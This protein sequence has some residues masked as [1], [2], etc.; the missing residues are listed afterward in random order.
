MPAGRDRNLKRV[1]PSQKKRKEK[2]A[3]DPAVRQRAA[4]HAAAAEAAHAAAAEAALAAAPAEQAGAAGPAREKAGRSCRSCGEPTAGHVGPYGPSCAAAKAL[5][6]PENMRS[7][8]GQ[9][10]LGSLTPSPVRG[11][12][13]QEAA[14]ADTSVEKIDE[15]IPSPS[16]PTPPCRCQSPASRHGICAGQTAWS[17]AYQVPRRWE[18]GTKMKDGTKNIFKC[19]TCGCCVELLALDWY[20]NR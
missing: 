9:G 3:A 13:R 8:R 11:G 18:D 4:D 17:R 1:A 7:A 12:G 19:T 6:T 16:P 10:E 14:E 15:E 5:A 20:T 2:R